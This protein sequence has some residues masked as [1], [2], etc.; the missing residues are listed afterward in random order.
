MDWIVRLALIIRLKADTVGMGIQ[1]FPAMEDQ[2][3]V[4]PKGNDAF[5]SEHNTASLAD[6]MQFLGDRVG[7]DLI[8]L[9][10][11]QSHQH[12]RVGPVTEAGQRQRAV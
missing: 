12:R 4:F 5:A 7:I 2:V 8:R 11:E 3:R 1:S 6:F 10:A 9:F